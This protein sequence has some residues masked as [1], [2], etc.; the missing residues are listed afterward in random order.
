MNAVNKCTF[1]KDILLNDKIKEKYHPNDFIDIVR[2]KKDRENIS[3]NVIDEEL[4]G[5]LKDLKVRLSEKLPDN[6]NKYSASW[7]QGLSTDHIGTLPKDVIERT[8][9]NENIEDPD[10]LC[11]AV[12]NSLYNVIMEE[13]IK[14]EEKDSLD[15]EIEAHK[16]F[17]IENQNFSL[18]EK[19]ILK[20]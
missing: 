13:I 20:K 11:V 5:K 12:W 15:I 4:S 19:E 16:D 6:I 7:N 17:G 2:V 10:K 18:E 8:E 1:D 9:A 3:Y 14:Y